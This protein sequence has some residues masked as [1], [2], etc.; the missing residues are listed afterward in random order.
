MTIRR[1]GMMLSGAL[2]TLV[3][4]ALV[5]AIA[6]GWRR[7]TFS[8]NASDSITA[9][10][11]LNKA[12]IELSLERSLAQ[13]GLALPGPFPEQFQQLLDEQRL[14]SDQNFQALE[15]HLEATDI[16]GE[17][18]FMSEVARLRQQISQ[19]RAAIDPD[20][21]VGMEARRRDGSEIV[22]LKAAISEL[23]TAGNMIRPSANQ[24]PGIVNAH[25]LLMQRAWI[26][27][28][29]GG[30]ERTYFAIG[31]ALGAAVDP[32]D[33]FEML[34]A[35]GRALQSWEL[36]QTL[37]EAAE[38]DPR[39]EERVRTM[40]AVYFGSYGDLREQL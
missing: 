40:G 21:T 15:Q 36:T 9:L 18:A 19:I 16:E 37:I 28:E 24:L 1:F 38:I 34:E 30:R 32:A 25:D 13:V 26:T 5:V 14:K 27:R 20:L 29:F 39:V 3:F 11:Y 33:R 4:L 2:A 10:S 17:A 22:R 23:N 35:H 7:L 31:T 12:T 8:T 6:S